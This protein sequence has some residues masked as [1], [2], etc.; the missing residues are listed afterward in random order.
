MSSTSQRTPPQRPSGGGRGSALIAGMI[1]FA[2]VFLLIVGG[3]VGFLVLRDSRSGTTG[4]ETSQA[5][6]TP[7]TETATPPTESVEEE[8]CWTPEYERTSTNPSGR[9]RGGGLEFV[10]PSDFTSRSNGTYA[11]FVNDAQTATAPLEGDWVEV[12]TVGAVQ[13]QPG[14]DYPGDKEASER[15]LECMYADGYLWGNTSE[16]SLHDQTTVPVTIA[17][18]PGYKTTATLE[19]GVDDLELIDA[20]TITVVVVDTPEGPSVFISEI[21]AGMTEHEEAAQEAYD[22][23]TGVSG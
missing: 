21:G 5:V 13:W 16:R 1:A 18:M 20:T 6:E 19:F 12:L 10:P 14:I 9:L 8:R 15:I 11:S 7:T 17:G 3:T 22:S 23:L 2:V 4:T